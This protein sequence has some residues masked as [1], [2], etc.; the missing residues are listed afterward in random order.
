MASV[1]TPRPSSLICQLSAIG[2]SVTI[3]RP[4][5]LTDNNRLLGHRLQPPGLPVFNVTI[6]LMGHRLEL[7]AFRSSLTTIGNCGIGFSYR[8]FGILCRQ[9]AIGAKD[10]ATL[11]PVFADNRRQ[12]GHRLPSHGSLPSLTTICY[13]GIG[14]NYRSSGLL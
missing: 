13:C 12:L 1:T 8:P 4:H 2:A 7:P 11:L 9:S 14:F 3:T 5:V 10:T 6:R